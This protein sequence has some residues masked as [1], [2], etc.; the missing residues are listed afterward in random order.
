[1]FGF[2]QQSFGSYRKKLKIFLKLSAFYFAS[3][4]LASLAVWGFFF[5]AFLIGSLFGLT[6]DSL[7][8][9]VIAIGA[10]VLSLYIGSGLFGSY[11]KNINSILQGQKIDFKSFF[12][13]GITKARTYFTI[14]I[15]KL[16][17][18][19]I[20]AA[21]LV[22]L[23][24]FVLKKLNIPYIEII[25]AVIF[26]GVKFLV[27]F[28]FIYSFISNALFETKAFASIRNAFRIIRNK[29]ISAF[30]LYTLFSII[31]VTLLIPLLNLI[32]LFV[33]LPISLGSLILVSNNGM[34]K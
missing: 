29:G 23:Y 8:V 31:A 20:L 26:V 14:L 22:A 6:L 15:I 13:Y 11:L 21:P 10:L 2:L 19:A 28:V 7:I 17:L 12:R 3:E 32:T 16:S 18:E 4:L 24:L 25:L 27:D 5:T 9:I 30:G 33:T 34:R 1:M